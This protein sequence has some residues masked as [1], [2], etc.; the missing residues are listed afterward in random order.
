M[1]AAP[2]ILHLL[3]HFTHAVEVELVLLSSP[4]LFQHV[5]NDTTSE[6]LSFHVCVT[7]QRCVFVC[8]SLLLTFF[9]AGMT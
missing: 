1:N 4:C 8:Y 2:T 9:A 5:H 3:S 7:Q 6:N